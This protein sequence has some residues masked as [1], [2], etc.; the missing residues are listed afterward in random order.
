LITPKTSNLFLK[1]DTSEKF[2]NFSLRDESH[3]H[4]FK[5]PQTFSS[6]RVESNNSKDFLNQYNEKN[7]ITK[8]IG[9]ASMDWAE[10]T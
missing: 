5:T 2:L 7:E 10:F 9:K 1:V 6:S 8:P 4:F 3:G